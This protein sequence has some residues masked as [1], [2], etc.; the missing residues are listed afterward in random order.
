MAKQLSHFVRVKEA[1]TD[2]GI[3]ESTFY[4][5]QETDPLFPPKAKRA[6]GKPLYKR[7]DIE[8]YKKYLYDGQPFSY[9]DEEPK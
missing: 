1:Y 4:R 6:V 8:K 2:L 3:S 7:S 5:W 9:D